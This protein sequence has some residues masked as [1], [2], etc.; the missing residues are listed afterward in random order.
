MRHGTRLGVFV[1]G[2]I[3]IAAAQASAR[4][5]GRPKTPSAGACF[6]EDIEFGGRYF[7]ARAGTS[8]T[9][10]TVRHQR[11]D[12]VD[13]H[14][15]ERAG[16]RLSRPQLQGT[17]AAIEA[18]TADLRQAGLNDRISSFR[19]ESGYGGN[20]GGSHGGGGGY[21]TTADGRTRRR[22]RWCGA[23]T[24]R[25]STRARCSQPQLHRRRHEEPLVPAATRE[26]VEEEPGVPRK[27]QTVNLANQTVPQRFGDGLG[28]RVDVQFAVDAFLGGT[29]WCAR[30]R[31]LGGGGLVVVTLHQEREQP[32]L[33]RREL[34]VVRSGGE[35]RGRRQLPG[36]RPRATSAPRRHR[37]AMHAD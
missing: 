1:A 17:V 23:R 9:K 36:G 13:S 24:S 26:R 25:F 27:A 14:L 15:R 21:I 16:H 3:L 5:W 32:D 28:L 34:V 10:I 29:K 35:S 31:R 7:C 4:Y 12:L 22:R 2:L 19:I 37:F 33:V 6:Y 18:N 30:S 11:R 20:W 8:T